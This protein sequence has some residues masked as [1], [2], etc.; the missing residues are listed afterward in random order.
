MTKKNIII[1]G[2]VVVVIIMAIVAFWPKK[3]NKKIIVGDSKVIIPPRMVIDYGSDTGAQNI[4]LTEKQYDEVYLIKEL[5]NKSPINR[6]YF[7]ID[8]NYQINKFVVIYKDLKNGATEFEKW[9][10]DTGYNGI[11]KEYFQIQ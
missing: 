7:S 3:E 2:A 11:S 5:R 10:N 8:F 6:T 9:L 4:S 1:L